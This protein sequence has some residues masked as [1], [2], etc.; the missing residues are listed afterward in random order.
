MNVLKT[1]AA[2]TLAGLL[3][4]CSSTSGPKTVAEFNKYSGSFEEHRSYALNLM[5]AAN[6]GGAKDARLKDGDSVIDLDES[7]ASFGFVDSL[8]SG[9]SL[10][11]ASLTGLAGGLL[12]PDSDAKYNQVIALIDITNLSEGDD[13]D[14]I[15][16]TQMLDK[17]GE[18]FSDA[19]GVSKS[20][21]SYAIYN[22][23]SDP[24]SESKN[25]RYA[26]VWT[27]STTASKCDE[28]SSS[29]Y[30][31][32]L[33]YGTS[34]TQA[35]LSDYE[36]R[37]FS[38]N[39]GMRFFGIQVEE[40][41]TSDKLPWLD[42]KKKYVIVTAKFNGSNVSLNYLSRQEIPVNGLYLYY[43]TNGANTGKAKDTGY[44]YIQA[45]HGKEMYF[46]KP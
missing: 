34:I 24:S 30:D 2:L 33:N 38:G 29:Y 37:F 17:F 42:T 25:G 10:L 36:S 40:I 3:T 13:I 4:A 39:C 22:K 8:A 20:A 18:F 1:T 23:A 26:S 12:T 6:L 44:P 32:A 35:A 21:V 46:I 16:R 41:V 9:G 14:A 28:L 7:N 31:E 5:E 45:P 27:D 19:I 43:T 15:A 11:S